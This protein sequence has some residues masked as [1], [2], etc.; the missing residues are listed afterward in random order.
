MFL[1]E[2]IPFYK[3]NLKVAIPIILSQLGGAI[4]QLF[5]SIMV[6]SLGTIPLAAVAFASAVFVIGFLFAIGLLQSIMPLV[7]YA[8]IQENKINTI[9]YFQN[10]F[11]VTLAVSIIMST[12]LYLISFV[13]EDMGQNAEVAKMAIPYYRLVVYSLTPF[14]FFEAMRQFLAGLGNTS[15]AMW[16]TL[17]ANIVNIIFNYIFIYGKF[18]FPEMGATG[19]GASTL[20]SR[21]IMPIMIAFA[22]YHKKTWRN[23]WNGMSWHLFSK[24]H[25]REMFRYGI[26]IALRT[27]LEVSAFAISGIMIG[28]LGASP[29]AANQLV[30]NMSHMTF[31]I[32]LGISSATTI[33][34]SHQ[35]G[36]K[37]YHALKMAANASIHLAFLNGIV[38][39]SLLILFRYPIIH[40][41]TNDPEVVAIAARLLIF[42]GAFQI[43]DG[44]QSVGIGI[45]NGLTDVKHT[46]IYAFISYICINLPLGYILAFKM[47]FG[48]DGI[49]I[50][51]IFGLAT[52]AVLLHQRCYKLISK[53]R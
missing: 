17:I 53:L 46:M 32:V 2:Y 21:C 49:W 44:L 48:P 51:F 11:S 9:T 47:D 52:A 5:D 28:W 7:G 27:V 3:R 23:Y 25:F 16:I 1:S 45:L 20:L 43:F 30:S 36:K 50:A 24:K 8:Y 15:V 41:F 4:V 10:S 37:D 29:Q 14:L 35:Y 34:V 42:S 19:A 26:P 6:G 12:I 33:R 22:I 13:M 38:M 31:M 18:G 39:G 40:W